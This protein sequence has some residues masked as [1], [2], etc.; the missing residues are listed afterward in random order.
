MRNQVKPLA[1]NRL[2]CPK[3]DRTRS[4]RDKYQLIYI[5]PVREVIHGENN[6]P[7]VRHFI[8]AQYFCPIC[9]TNYFDSVDESQV[10]E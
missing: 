9:C 6:G 3:C 1:V 4:R 10:T 7:M 2:F 5:G 8:V